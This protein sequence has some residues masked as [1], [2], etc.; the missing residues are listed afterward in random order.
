MKITVALQA[1]LS[2]PPIVR[3]FL[4]DIVDHRET[5]PIN[6]AIAALEE[7]Y[8]DAPENAIIAYEIIG[9]KMNLKS[10]RA[11]YKKREHKTAVERAEA[12]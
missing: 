10:K 1:F 2:L 3:E 9:E 7:I 5:A 4:L 8:Q 12:A 11:P 6:R